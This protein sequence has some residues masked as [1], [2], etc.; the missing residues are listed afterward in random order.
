MS[1]RHRSVL[2]LFGIILW[3]H[4]VS[5]ANSDTT[6][7]RK[8]RKTP[9]VIDFG[10]I[11]CTYLSNEE[12]RYHQNIEIRQVHSKID[13]MWYLDNSYENAQNAHGALDQMH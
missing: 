4:G 13:A 6:N 1:L 8:L 5:N 7:H 11:L 12:E 9:N 2:K 3:H 10:Y